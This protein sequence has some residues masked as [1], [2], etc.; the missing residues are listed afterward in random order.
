[1]GFWVVEAVSHF[2]L[3]LHEPP[4]QFQLDLLPVYIS[5]FLSITL[6]KLSSLCQDH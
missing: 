5:F 1:M 6:E 4:S 2:L 3:N